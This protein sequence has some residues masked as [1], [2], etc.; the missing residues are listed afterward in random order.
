M[1]QISVESLSDDLIIK[2]NGQQF[3]IPK[4]D[5]KKVEADNTYDGHEVPEAITIGFPYSTSDRVR[6][7]TD[8]NVYL[9]FTSQST[10]KERIQR[11]VH[12]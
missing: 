12:T 8:D 5:I 1:F 3:V 11:I 7:T 2:W 6:I 4:V 9:L 10:L